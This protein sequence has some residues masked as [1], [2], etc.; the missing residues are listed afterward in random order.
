MSTSSLLNLSLLFHI[1]GLVAVAGSN[2]VGYV[3]QGQFWKQ[4]EQDSEKGMAVMKASSKLPAVMGIG[5]LVI[6]LSGISLVAITHGAY[7]QQF[8]FRVKMV[9]L[10][11]IIINGVVFGRRNDN[12]LK[13]LVT[14]NANG[15]D[16][17]LRSVRSRVNTF[18]LIQIV[19]LLTIF[20]LSVFKFS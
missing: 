20:T 16:A 5:F 15:N 17:A 13:K 18:Y 10:V 11:C 4:Y 3:L 6:L 9:V 8:W 2:L 1:I 7:A 14:E 19:L 12:Q